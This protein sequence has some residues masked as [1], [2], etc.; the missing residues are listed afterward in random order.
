MV[1]ADHSYRKK[2][3]APPYDSKAVFV[4]KAYNVLL[5]YIYIHA[6]WLA[7]VLSAAIVP[8]CP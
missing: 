6:I 4:N 3:Y 8:I 7:H 1:V 5:Y 2:P